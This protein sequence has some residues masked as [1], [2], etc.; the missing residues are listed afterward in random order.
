[1][2][3]R[4]L[5]VLL[6]AMLSVGCSNEPREATGPIGAESDGM[7][8]LKMETVELVNLR[9]IDSNF[10]IEVIYAT[11]ENF[12]GKQLYPEN[13]LFILPEVGESLSR[14]NRKLMDEHGLR[15]KVWD[16]YRP[17]SVQKLMWEIVPDERY[18]ADPAKGSRHN[19]GCAVDVTLVD[20]DGNE[21]E[22]PT[23]FDDFSER[24]HLD[25]MDLPEQV[26]Q[27]RELLIQAMQSEGFTPLET[28]WWH[29][30]YKGWEDHPV[31]DVNPYESSMRN[32]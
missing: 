16:A 19:R 1:M 10:V 22:M 31:L 28:E 23:G 32:S 8:T 17:L 13:E 21:L 24:A 3:R 11:T 4:E 20:L 15:L 5:F 9:D 26:L 14:V 30:D 2:N 12:T 7:E 25:Y 18:V 6:L 27:N 29:F